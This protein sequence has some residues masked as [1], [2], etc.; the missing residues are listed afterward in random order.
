MYE[1]EG[2]YINKLRNIN[3][4]STHSNTSFIGRFDFT[5]TCQSRPLSNFSSYFELTYPIYPPNFYQL[6]LNKNILVGEQNTSIIFENYN[7][8]IDTTCSRTSSPRR[9]CTAGI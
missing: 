8:R 4:F 5:P 9:M 3:S 7:H 6:Y 1:I 2:M